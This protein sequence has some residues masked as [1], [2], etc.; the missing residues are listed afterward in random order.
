MSRN[1]SAARRRRANGG[2]P[3]YDASVPSRKFARC[4]RRNRSPCGVARPHRTTGCGVGWAPCLTAGF[5]RFLVAGISDARRRFAAGSRPGCG[6]P[7]AMRAERAPGSSRSKFPRVRGKRTRDVADQ[8]LMVDDLQEAAEIVLRRGQRRRVGHRVILVAG[9]R[10]DV[11]VRGRLNP[12]T[13]PQAVRCRD[14]C[15]AAQGVGRDHAPIDAASGG[16]QQK[17]PGGGELEQGLH[18]VAPGLLTMK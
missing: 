9:V 13:L 15:A 16:T 5:I 1:E 3:E 8:R 4:S 10:N 2:R 14:A 18:R 7:A 11:P 6:E 17:G 12:A